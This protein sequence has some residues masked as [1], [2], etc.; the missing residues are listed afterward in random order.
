M[1]LEPAVIAPVSLSLHSKSI[2]NAAFHLIAPPHVYPR[3]ISAREL[4]GSAK[5]SDWERSISVAEQDQH[6]RG[7]ILV[8]PPS[9]IIGALHATNTTRSR[10]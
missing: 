9:I 2:Q 7:N 6:C 1:V 8:N 10:D 3:I 5:D 4:T